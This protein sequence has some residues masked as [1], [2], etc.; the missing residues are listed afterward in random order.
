LRA[1]D[2]WVLGYGLLVLAVL[3][4][5][6]ARG[7]PGCRPQAALTL[8]VLA[9]TAS[10][11]WASRDTASRPLTFLR[12]SYAPL[13]FWLFYHQVPTLWPILRAAPLDGHLAALELRLWGGQPA[14]AFQAALP[15]RGLSET[16]CFAYFSYYLFV[17]A[18]GLTALASRGYLAAERILLATTGCFFVCYTLFWLLPTVGPHY[19]FPPGLGPQLYRGY[20]FNHLLFFFTSGGEIRGGAFPSSHI[21]VATLL[22]LCARRTT[23]ALWPA[24]AVV[25]AL[26]LPAVVYLRAHYLV[27][28]PAGLLTG[29]VAYRVSGR[30]IPGWQGPDY[31][32]NPARV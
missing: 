12:L 8:A 25:T 27:D 18:V 3:A 28:V 32:K 9:G 31:D 19:W 5:G 29:L 16:F 30:F 4:L 24:M 15:W 17:P 21:A 20:V 23:P 6:L 2:A 26:M 13:L 1:L 22:T 11:A 7:V 14:L 10:L